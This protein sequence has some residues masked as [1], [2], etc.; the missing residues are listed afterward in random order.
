M[1]NL[2]CCRSANYHQASG[3]CDLSEMDRITLSATSSFQQN[4][5]KRISTSNYI[6]ASDRHTHTHRRT[7]NVSSQQSIIVV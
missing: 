6:N 5:G 4:D 1:Q 3:A 7:Y 2:S